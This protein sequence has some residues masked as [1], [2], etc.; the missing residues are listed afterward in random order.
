MRK[1]IAKV[2]Q[3][4]SGLGLKNKL[5]SINILLI[6]MPVVLLDIY[7]FSATMKTSRSNALDILRSGQQNIVQ[8]IESHAGTMEKMA[9]VLALDIHIQ[10]M[11]STHYQDE[12]QRVIDYQLATSGSVGHTLKFSPDVNAIYLYNDDIVICEMADSF[13]SVQREKTPEL[14]SKL[15]LDFP[16]TSERWQ[17][18]RNGPHNVVRPEISPSDV[19]SYQRVILS[20]SGRRCGVIEIV[21]DKDEL[22]KSMYE[23]ELLK[24]GISCIVDESG[25]V[26]YSTAQGVP[27][28]V[29]EFGFEDYVFGETVERVANNALQIVLPISVLKASLVTTVPLSSLNDGMYRSALVVVTL[30]VVL[31]VICCLCFSLFAQRQLKSI[32]PMMRAMHQIR[33]G[34]FATRVPIESQDE[35]GELAKDFNYMSEKLQEQ[36]DKVYMAGQMEREAELRALAANIN[37]HF[38][39]NSLATIT[40]MARAKHSPEIVEITEAL[41]RL[42]RVVLSDGRAILSFR[43][44]ME[45]VNSYLKVQQMRF[46]DKC[47]VSIDVTENALKFPVIKN[48]VQP[49]VENAL[50]H[51][52]GPKIGQ[53]AVSVRADVISDRLEIIVEDNGVGMSEER[54]AE[55]LFGKVGQRGRG[56]AIRNIQDRL[57]VIYEGRYEFALHSTEGVGTTVRLVLPRPKKMWKDDEESV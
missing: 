30:S 21:S 46:E 48:I 35:L 47:R 26:L 22:L 31:M 18:V 2:K 16:D 53:G 44:E 34:D 51:G 11:F 7:F 24:G 6:I 12:T 39:Y 52:I 33:K 13:F 20:T 1:L 41:A 55:V 36:V 23:Q 45:I 14:F 43:D 28:T 8:S 54:R 9:E 42:Y 49:L 29:Q 15:N 38:L 25:R 3:F 57:N 56:Y 19:I 32:P 5:L 27:D 10:T 4:W 50:D 17:M 40:W 37:P